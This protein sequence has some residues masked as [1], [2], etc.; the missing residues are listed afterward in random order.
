MNNVERARCIIQEFNKN[1][2]PMPCCC[3]AQNNVVPGNVTFTIGTVTTGLPGSQ[4]AASITGV[5]PNFILN[6]TIPQGATGP[7]GPMGA[8][9]PQGPQ[10]IQ[11]IEGPTGPT[12]ATGPTGPTG[13]T[14]ATGPEAITA[15]GGIYSTDPVA[16]T[17]TTPN[18]YE[19]VALDETLPNQNVTYEP[20]NNITINEAGTYLINY[21]ALLS[22]TSSLTGYAAVRRNEGNLAPT[23]TSG[24]LSTTA[25]VPFNGVIIQELNE[26]DVLDIA[27]T[28]STTDSITVNNGTLVVRRIGD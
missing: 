21:D 13:A 20:A 11:G 15:Y 14:G 19:E 9:G 2:R 28:G 5:Y 25:T 23:V 22:S 7:T 27:V 8:T 4:A 26:G 12:G 18:T 10:G 17:I 6:L 1:Y 3:P 24:E 16:V